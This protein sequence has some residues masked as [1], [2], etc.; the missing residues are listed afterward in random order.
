MEFSFN[1]KKALYILGYH[2]IVIVLFLFLFFKGEVNFDLLFAYKVFFNPF[3]FKSVFYYLY[4]YYGYL[5]IIIA[6]AISSI[7][8][9]LSLWHND[10]ITKKILIIHG[11]VPLWGSIYGYIFYHS[12]FIKFGFFGEILGYVLKYYCVGWTV[13][14]FYFFSVLGFV[15][16][17]Q[18]KNIIILIKFFYYILEKLKIIA[19]LKYFYTYGI[20]WLFFFMP[21]LKKYYKSKNYIN[22]DNLINRSIYADFYSLSQNFAIDYYLSGSQV[23]ENRE[24]LPCQC[25]IKKDN[26]LK[27]YKG[28]INKE[29]VDL[30]LEAF[31][32]FDIQLMFVASMVGPLLNTIIVT[33]HANIKLSKI[34]QVL[35]DVARIIGK[36][37]MRF[38]YPVI[39]YPHAVAFEYA[40]YQINILHFLDYAHDDYF[41]NSTPLTVLLGVNTCG[42]PYYIDIAKAPHMLLAGTTGSGK[43]N[44]LNLCI[45]ELIW[46]NSV[47]TVQLILLDPKKSEFFLFQSLPHLLFPIAQSLK[48]IEEAIIHAIMIMEQRYDLFNKA[49]CKNIYEYNE[50]YEPIS[51]IV[52]FI[53]EYADIVIQSKSTELKIIRLLQMSRAAG[54]HVIIATQ[55]PSADIISSIVKSNLPVRIACKVISAI[56]SRII[57]DIDGAEKLLGNSDILI[58]VN[59]KYD[60]VHG[61]FISTEVIEKV[62][63]CVERF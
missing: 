47:K 46:K 63:K 34:N 38:I 29:E 10:S 28:E 59:N 62:V 2:L 52:I 1:R 40:H 14:I 49:Y 22:I 33:P 13:W 45:A 9:M 50:T 8:L 12:T 41:L 48:E 35:S 58:L 26:T 43:S 56:N 25:I 61:L 21:V 44:I 32:H 15:F 27:V 4:G 11:L 24:I 16:I 3:A 5:G 6:Y 54:M 7:Y 18:L 39:G 57:L 51:F 60:R 53:D 19:F 42:A 30:L 31:M 55:R 36:P 17:M 37:D 23:E 20:S